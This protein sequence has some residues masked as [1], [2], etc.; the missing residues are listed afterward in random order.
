MVLIK[1][2]N[3]KKCVFFIFPGNGQV[4]LGMPDTAALN[5]INLN[6]DSIQA[7]VAECKTNIKQ[8]MLTVSKG[9]TNMD[10][11]VNTQ[12]NANSQNDQNNSN[13]SINY[14]FLSTNVNADQGKC[15]AMMQ[16]I[17]DT[18]GD[19]FNGIACF[20]GTFSL[21]LKPNSKPY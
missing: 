11:G 16:K 19:I 3:V 21:Q 5:I 9:C 10:T 20:E 15:I 13:K 12:Q 8:E 14:F 17:H 2:K 4:L 18:F 7:E 1:F 6:I